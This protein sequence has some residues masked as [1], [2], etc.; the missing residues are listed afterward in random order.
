MDILRAQGK[1]TPGQQM[2]ALA[3]AT[4][5]AGLNLPRG[6]KPEKWLSS[7]SDED[8]SKIVDALDAQV[9]E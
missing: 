5:T 2:A 9:T 4:P 7:L 6:S 3:R 8:L 1:E